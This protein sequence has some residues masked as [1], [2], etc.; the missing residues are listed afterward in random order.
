[1]ASHKVGGEVDAFCTKCKMT[2]AHTILAMVGTKIARVRC[3]TCFGDH[4][5]RSA[6]G[7]TTR[8]PSAS[9]APKEK[10]E[11]VVIS[12][13]DQLAGKDLSQAVVYS[14]KQRFQVDQIISH[15]TF[16]YGIVT[17]VRN[18]K[19]DVAF[20]AMQKTLIHAREGDAQAKPTFRP[21]PGQSLAPADKPQ[22]S[23]PEGAAPEADAE[24][25]AEPPP[26]APGEAQEP[27]E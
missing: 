25:A 7:T 11:K 1:M 21:P 12:F 5:F 2:L 13:Q 27:A 23:G 16:G 18:D 14:P 6:P 3:N 26:E 19:V 22:A 15:P 17:A 8:T 9:R 20:K 10:V 24:A 4:A